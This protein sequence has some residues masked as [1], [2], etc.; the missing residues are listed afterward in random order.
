MS[1]PAS[2]F[3]RQWR[4]TTLGLV[5]VMSLIAFE[6]MAVATALP[7]TVAELDGLAYYGWPFTAFLI[8]NILGMVTA[9]ALGDR[10][11]PRLPLLGGIAIFTAGLVLAGLATSMVVFV[12]GRSVQGL[13][14]GFVIVAVYVVLGVVYPDRA[15][16]RV[17]AALSAAWVVPA[18]LGP[19]VAGA[20]TE[21]L[22][23]RLVFLGLPPFIA[24]GL[25]LLRPALA[26]LPAAA[27]ETTLSQSAAAR[28]FAALGAGS[29]I[30][31]LLYA[32]QRYAGQGTDLLGG[33]ALLAGAVLLAVSVR[34]L[35]PP[36]TVAV[37]RGL[38]AVIAFRGMLA[39]AFF[40]VDALLPLTLTAVHGYSPTAA[41]IPLM[42]GAV[43][44]STGSWLQGR[45]PDV[46]RYLLLRAG[47]ALVALSCTAMVLIVLP[48]G[49]GWTAYPIWFVAGL[50]MGLA[51]PSVGVLLLELSPPEQ[52]GANSAAMQI[53]DVI[54]AALCIG[55]GGVLVAASEN[56]LLPLPIAVGTVDLAMALIAFAG[57]LLAYRV[58]TE[59]GAQQ[60]P[61]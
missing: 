9:G 14:S 13:G 5:I 53:S 4:N 54:A 39:G 21:H 52:R 18:L 35:L 56:G 58:R 46:P 37:R 22:T 40:A 26:A 17:F 55:F 47:F 10:L 36:G 38:P 31:L 11:G 51:M 34:R 16:P 3:D 59:V 8:A 61:A 27:P 19:P 60:V 15:R 7:T 28:T 6:A 23:W 25:L 29:G 48:V 49:M 30:A 1:T 12:L 57:V 20:I 2:A 24:V 32:G 44:W 50:G 42:A 45:S 33:A 43:G 41:G